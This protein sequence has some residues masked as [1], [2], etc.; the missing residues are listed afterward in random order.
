MSGDV[1]KR[2]YAETAPSGD[3]IDGL[4]GLAGVTIRVRHELTDASMRL[5]G[6]L[7]VRVIVDPVHGDRCIR[8]DVGFGRDEPSKKC[9]RCA[10]VDREL[11]DASVAAEA[12][13]K[14]TILAAIDR[15]RARATAARAYPQSRWFGWP[16]PPAQESS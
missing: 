15:A 5:M 8:V 14:E 16:L 3:L 10:A 2:L 7:G 12:A 6:T 4:S 9:R 1:V 11:W 13:A